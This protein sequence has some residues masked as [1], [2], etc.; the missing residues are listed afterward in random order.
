MSMYFSS[1]LVKAALVDQDFRLHLV[2][3]KGPSDSP[4]VTSASEFQI[5]LE[6]H[7]ELLPLY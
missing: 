4:V 3:S 2:D 5:R 6:R 1:T 7:E